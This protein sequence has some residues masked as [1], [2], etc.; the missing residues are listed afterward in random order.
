MSKTCA[1]G[2]VVSLAVLFA[3][4]AVLGQQSEKKMPAPFRPRPSCEPDN[5]ISKV[6][7]LPSF[8]TPVELQDVVN[9]FRT[10]ADM[11]DVYPNASEHT[12]A[13]KATP[14]Q[15]AIAEK[16]VGVFE[17]LR[18]SGG[19]NSS[20]VLVYEFKGPLSGTSEAERILA[21]SPSLASTMC[22]LTTCV[23]KVL[24]LPNFSAPSEIQ[25]MVNMFR[26]IADI[27]RIVPT[28]EHTIALKG[29]PEQ[30]AI[31]EKLVGVLENLRSSGG[32]KRSS[33][34]VYQPNASLPVPTV[35]EDAA[36]SP[37]ELTTCYIKALYLPDFSTVQL[38]D[39]VNRVRTTT[40]INRT[41]P[42]QSSHVIVVRG[43]AEQVAVAE[44]LA[45][46]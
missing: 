24:L 33:V 25:D 34:L 3:A 43:T 22:E 44:K 38:Q 40:Q 41:M 6:L 13:I 9:T 18:A 35:S 15:L 23:I 26:T 42:I 17:S 31:G 16:L 8:A 21:K 46:E 27:T 19:R 12:I 45:N 37:C 29:T 2:F 14:E 5:C 36:R 39:L 20:S 32:Q 10:V 11:T 1:R 4:S 28:Y 7:S 30:I